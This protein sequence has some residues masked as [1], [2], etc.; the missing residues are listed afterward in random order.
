MKISDRV[1]I[2][3]DMLNNIDKNTRLKSVK[4]LTDSPARGAFF[5]GL[6]GK[7]TRVCAGKNRLESSYREDLYQPQMGFCGVYGVSYYTGVRFDIV[8]DYMRARFNK[9][10]TWAGTTDYTGREIEQTI[11]H[12]VGADMKDLKMKDMA[13][14]NLQ[15]RE[16]R[17]YWI[18]IRKHVFVMNGK[19]CVDQ[20]ETAAQTEHWCKNK[21]VKRVREI[22][23][24][25]KA[26]V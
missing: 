1:K 14:K 5:L 11:N 13:V 20:S 4:W 3:E 9:G 24:P 2:A 10:G 22:V 16:D 25:Q 18:D 23:M 7:G 15:L 12:F 8:F 26:T 6:G 19:W 21:I 17:W